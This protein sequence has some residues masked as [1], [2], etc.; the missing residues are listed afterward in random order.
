MTSK[1]SYTNS[2][3]DIYHFICHVIYKGNKMLPIVFITLTS[4]MVLMSFFISSYLTAM[5]LLLYIVS[6]FFY[7]ISLMRKFNIFTSGFEL[8]KLEISIEGMKVVNSKYEGFYTWDIVNTIESNHKYIFILTTTNLVYIIPRGAFL[9]EEEYNEFLDLV[10]YY[11]YKN[12]VKEEIKHKPTSKRI[13]ET[14]PI[15]VKEKQKEKNDDKGNKESKYLCPMF[16]GEIVQI[17]YKGVLSN[18]CKAC[19]Q[20]F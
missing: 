2:K 3:N 6:M 8:I 15:K 20:I 1:I 5:I 16:N 4:S 9:S 7:Y 12:K 17:I 18:K 11:F 14:G 13:P 19:H 10:K